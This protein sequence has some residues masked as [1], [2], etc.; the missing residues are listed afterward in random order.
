MI[1]AQTVIRSARQQAH[2]NKVLEALDNADRFD[3]MI[4]NIRRDLLN[5]IEVNISIAK[6]DVDKVR[7]SYT[8]SPNDDFSQLDRALLVYERMLH[9]REALLGFVPLVAPIEVEL[10]M[11]ISNPSKEN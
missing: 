4:T 6:C 11:K 9:W 7:L 3:I 1:N 10:D 5:L 8:N 2:I